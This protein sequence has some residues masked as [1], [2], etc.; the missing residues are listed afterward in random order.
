MLVIEVNNPSDKLT[1]EMLG[2]MLGCE[3]T[4]HV[5]EYTLALEG[6]DLDG[7]MVFIEDQ[8]IGTGYF[9]W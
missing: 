2:D 4:E 1:V 5:D 7:L 6:G 3:V 9:D 8:G